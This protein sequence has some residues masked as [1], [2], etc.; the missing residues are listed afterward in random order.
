M[1]GMAWFPLGLIR[2]V[3]GLQRRRDLAISLCALRIRLLFGL[4]RQG[5]GSFVRDNLLNR[6]Q[7][8]GLP[9]G[10]V[11]S[12]RGSNFLYLLIEGLLYCRRNCCAE[13]T[14]SNAAA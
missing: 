7:P 8:N 1:H 3:A 5:S 12:A 13:S 9:G 6:S 2:L 14:D 11:L 10:L 4:L